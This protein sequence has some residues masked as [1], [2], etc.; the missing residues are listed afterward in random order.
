MATSVQPAFTD[1]CDD[2]VG[3]VAQRF[4]R[5]YARVWLEAVAASVPY[6]RVYGRAEGRMGL[7]KGCAD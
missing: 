6:A 4:S 7:L 2:V 3:K 5:G 1:R